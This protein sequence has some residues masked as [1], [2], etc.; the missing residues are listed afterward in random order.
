VR[1]GSD[2]R[3]RYGPQS[4]SAGGAMKSARHRGGITS[5][6]VEATV[7]MAGNP[8]FETLWMRPVSRLRERTGLANSGRHLRFMPSASRIWTASIAP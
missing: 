7:R 8:G 4:A 1:T 6:P 5:N 3:Y 2:S